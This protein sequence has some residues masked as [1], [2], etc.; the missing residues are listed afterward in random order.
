M[1]SGVGRAKLAPSGSGPAIK[2][3]GIK[4]FQIQGFDV[5]ASGKDVAIE[6]SGY[7]NRSSLKDLN[8][9]GFSKVCISMKG[10]VGFN[11]E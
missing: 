8:V 9:S 4:F 6:L 5:D 3:V 10:A 2:L 7:L 1:S 11:G